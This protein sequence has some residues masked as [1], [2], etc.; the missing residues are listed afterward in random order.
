MKDMGEVT[1]YMFLTIMMATRH[2]FLWYI[3]YCDGGGMT[4]PIFGILKT[5]WKVHSSC[6][7]IIF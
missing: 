3:P 5:L 6:D 1:I 2:A 7:L 4:G